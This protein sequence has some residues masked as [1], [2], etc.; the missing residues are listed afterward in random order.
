M[1]LFRK[2]PTV[3]NVQV[4]AVGHRRLVTIACSNDKDRAS[5][6]ADGLRGLGFQ[7]ILT[8]KEPKQ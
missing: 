3:Y 2:K 6:I 4:K 8:W 1:S 7:V 5:L